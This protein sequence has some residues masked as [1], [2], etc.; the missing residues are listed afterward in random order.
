MI[1]YIDIVNVLKKKLAKGVFSIPIRINKK[2]NKRFFENFL[3][4]FFIEDL[5][6]LISIEYKNQE[7]FS[8]LI[9][10][11]RINKSW[12]STGSLRHSEKDKIILNYLQGEKTVFL[13]IG[14]SDGITSFELI[15]NMNNKFKKYYVTDLFFNVGF[16]EHNKEIFFYLP[17][18][19]MCFMIVSNN[20]TFYRDIKSII[21]PLNWISG[22]KFLRCPQYDENKIKNLN[23]LNPL[24]LNLRK[25]N[26]KI[27][28]LEW[29]LFKDWNNERPDFIKLANV[30][31][32]VYFNNRQICNAI[33][34]LRNILK[35]RGYLILIENRKIAKWSIFRK[36]NSKLKL[37]SH[38]NGGSEIEHL[39]LQGENK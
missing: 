30:L 25:K 29:D 18:T 4:L 17:H 19:K 37:V 33:N 24:M 10:L 23:I 22:L 16:L 7:E 15:D 34:N 11:M 8:Q 5:R 31:N 27:K 21:F 12:K 20:F 13:D 2:K 9:S 35:N 1:N 3:N 36:E 28:I 38:G 26:K 39:V 6:K 14:V 32:R